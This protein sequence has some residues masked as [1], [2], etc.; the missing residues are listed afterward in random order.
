MSAFFVLF[1]KDKDSEE[2]PQLRVD[3]SEP[4]TEAREETVDK[5]VDL[6]Y[7]LNDKPPWYLCILLGFQV[8]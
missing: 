8:K 2:R 5:G 3:I 6:V 1:S 4:H 7:A